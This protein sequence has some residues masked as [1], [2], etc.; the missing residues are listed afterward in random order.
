MM[1][2]RKIGQT[3]MNVAPIGLGAMGMD[4]AYGVQKDRATMIQLL[5]Q[6]VDMGYELFDTAPVYGGTNEALLGEA[7]KNRR[8]EVK[9]V[10]KFGITGQEMVN[11]HLENILNSRPD[12]LETQLQESLSQLQTDYID[13]YLQ[14]RIDPDVQPEEVANKM[15][16][17][18]KEGKIHAW[19]VSW[20]TPEAPIDYL[21]RAHKICPISVVECQYSMVYRKPEK[22]IFDFCE[23]HGISLLAYSPLG[24]GFLSGAFGSNET[25]SKNDFRRSMGRFSQEV[26]QKN[27]NVLDEIQ[28]IADQKNATLAQITLAWEIGQQPFIIPI[29]GTTKLNRLKENIQ[30]T[31]VELT[32]DEINLINQVLNDLNIDETHF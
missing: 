27:Q 19:G 11:G 7:F 16:Q 2:K 30:S 29:P 1:L 31:E 17:F 13:I 15:S 22:T 10:T 26:M 18:M 20:G 28:K 5:N 25:F 6:A 8:D 3:D 21:E 12:S 14:H 32:R 24:N 9:L 23:R 4:H